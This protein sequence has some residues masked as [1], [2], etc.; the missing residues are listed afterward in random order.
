MTKAISAGAG[1]LYIYGNYSGDVINFDMAAEMASME[2]IEVRSVLGADDVAS[3]PRTETEKRRGVAGIFYLYKCAGGAADELRAA[4][5]RRAR[6]PEGRRERPH[7]G[8]RVDALYRP[9]GR[10]AGI[11]ARRPGDGNRHGDSRRARHPPR[12][13]LSADRVV[14]EMLPAILDDLPFERGD[15][16]SVLVNGLGATPKEELY[17]LFRRVHAASCRAGHRRLQ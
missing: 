17:I 14:D 15:T 11:R 6:R 12:T 13:L 8:G 4:R 16:V 7:D 9:A 3:A 2:D 10:H 5:R 1:V